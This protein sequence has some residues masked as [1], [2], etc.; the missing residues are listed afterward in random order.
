M[1]QAT[2]GDTVHIHYTGTLADGTEFDSSRGRE[3]LRFTLGAGQVVP[4][5]DRAVD[6]MAEGQTQT[7][8]I[9]AA[10]AYGEH[11]PEN[12][13]VVPAANLPT[14]VVLGDRLALGTPDGGQVAVTVTAIDADGATLDANHDLAGKD[15]TFEITLVRIG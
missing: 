12:T 7:V 14:G 9:P 2:T 4:G 11:D 8:T 15:L 13:L 5:F 10:E 6:G 1:A 3:P